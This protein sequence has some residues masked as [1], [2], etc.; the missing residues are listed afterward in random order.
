MKYVAQYRLDIWGDI[1]YRYLIKGI[2]WTT[3]N[4]KTA[5]SLKEIR[6]GCK[7]Y[8]YRYLLNRLNIKIIPL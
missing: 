1:T 6:Q 2:K 7:E 4:N 5:Y 3:I 8:K